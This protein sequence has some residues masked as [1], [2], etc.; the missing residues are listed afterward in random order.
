M[1]VTVLGKLS[2]NLVVVV[3]IIVTMLEIRNSDN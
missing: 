1:N 3:V 2:N